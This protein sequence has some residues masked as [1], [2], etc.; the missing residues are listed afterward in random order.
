M[1]NPFTKSMVRLQLPPGA[2]STVSVSG[3]LLEADSEGCIEV[4]ATVV[5][6]LKAHGLTEPAPKPA[7]K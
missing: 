6:E 3:F 4:P 7:K 1:T 2:G 5:T